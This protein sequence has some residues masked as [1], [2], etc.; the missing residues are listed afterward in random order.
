MSLIKTLGQLIDIYC[1]LN[2][3]TGE[4]HLAH[5]FFVPWA[6]F[7]SEL[8]SPPHLSN[9]LPECVPELAVSL[10]EA[11]VILSMHSQNIYVLHSWEE[12]LHVNNAQRRFNL[13]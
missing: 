8:T 3:I 11:V 7:F 10:K 5:E 9:P 2:Q 12:G 1:R 4:F 6:L 13:N